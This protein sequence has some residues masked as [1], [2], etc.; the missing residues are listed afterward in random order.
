MARLR[1]PRRFTAQHELIED[2]ILRPP[3][4]LASGLNASSPCRT[5]G[6]PS[7]TPVGLVVRGRNLDPNG[8]V[9]FNDCSMPAAGKVIRFVLTHRS[10]RRSK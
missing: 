6:T 7:T 9:G 4:L 2:Y 5:A 8:I 3:R 10:T 1:S